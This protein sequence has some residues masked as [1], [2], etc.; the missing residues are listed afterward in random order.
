MREDIRGSP[1]LIHDILQLL[2]IDKC[3]GACAA[4]YGFMGPNGAVPLQ[5][6]KL[7]CNSGEA[8]SA[9]LH[10]Y[11]GIPVDDFLAAVKQKIAGLSSG[12]ASK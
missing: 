2:F 1:P 12:E 8:I 4:P 7:V 6:A 11:C 3:V 10:A 9:T 5:N